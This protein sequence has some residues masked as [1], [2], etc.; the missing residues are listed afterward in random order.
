[1]TVNAF[2]RSPENQG[3]ADLRGVLAAAAE[4]T[5]R[6]RAGLKAAGTPEDVLAVQSEGFEQG[7]IRFRAYELL[8]RISVHGDARLRV[9]LEPIRMLGRRLYRLDREHPEPGYGERR[10][11]EVAAEAVGRGLPAKLAKATFAAAWSLLRGEPGEERVARA[12]RALAEAEVRRRQSMSWLES[13][14][15]GAASC[16]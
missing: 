3:S 5:R 11:L 13:G 15:S 1:M 6:F 2:L 8:L 12:E 16:G 4:D 10:M 14:P 7:R 9:F